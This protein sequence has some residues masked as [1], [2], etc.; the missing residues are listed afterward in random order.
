MSE[1]NYHRVTFFMMIFV[2]VLLEVMSWLWLTG[3]FSQ[4]YTY[5]PLTT[6]IPTFKI[7]P[8]PTL[9]MTLRPRLNI[10]ILTNTIPT[11]RPTLRPSLIP[12]EYFTQMP[13]LHITAYDVSNGEQFGISG[14]V[15]EHW[16]IIGSPYYDTC[17]G[18]SYFYRRYS[19]V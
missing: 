15:F 8:I 13:L 16:A 5:T 19:G 4:G 18:R 9:G 11:L 7:T 2:V 10:T 6:P 12:A 1:Q 3:K 14:S 17:K